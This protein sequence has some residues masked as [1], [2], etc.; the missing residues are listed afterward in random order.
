M[1]SILRHETA[2]KILRIL[3]KDQQLAHHELASKLEIS[4]Q[5]L[6]WQMAR[7]KKMEIVDSVTENM[8]VKYSIN[9][10]NATIISWCLNSVPARF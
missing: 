10:K 1:I 2:G 6:S 4:S 9:E 7:L 5:A 3:S 8:E